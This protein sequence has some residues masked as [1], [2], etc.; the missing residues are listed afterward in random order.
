ME[1]TST[2]IYCWQNMSYTSWLFV[3]VYKFAQQDGNPSS[4]K[5]TATTTSLGVGDATN[6]D[7]AVLPLA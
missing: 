3:H 5:G 6:V 7:A 2:L 1:S 4:N